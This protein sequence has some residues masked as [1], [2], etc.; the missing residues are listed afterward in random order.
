[1]ISKE[2][3]Q[4][5]E[6]RISEDLY[7]EKKIKTDL[8]PR[9]G[10]PSVIELNKVILVLDFV[11]KDGKSMSQLIKDKNINNINETS[12]VSLYHIGNKK[13]DT[14]KIGY[15]K[16]K[17]M[18]IF[19]A[20][21]FGGLTN[22]RLRVGNRDELSKTKIN[23]IQSSNINNVL[24]DIY[25]TW[26]KLSKKNRLYGGIKNKLK[27][28]ITSVIKYIHSQEEFKSVNI[29]FWK[30]PKIRRIVYTSYD[31]YKMMGV[32]YLRVYG[33]GDSNYA[34]ITKHS[35]NI[36]CSISKSTWENKTHI[37]PNINRNN[38]LN[39]YQIY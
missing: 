4:K 17:N 30:M 19:P 39:E 36:F 18:V 27:L 15:D 6:N 29:R 8:V 26:K 28:F 16:D 1:M 23:I 20:T 13:K 12:Y 5:F 37:T 34:K 2:E 7:H 21:D 3:Y 33:K 35:R 32:Y 31:I 24:N 38:I 22:Y 14:V 25:Y 11:N 9:I 10:K